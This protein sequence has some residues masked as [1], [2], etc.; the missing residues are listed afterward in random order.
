M[1]MFQHNQSPPLG[2]HQ[3]K[4]GIHST[5]LI[6][7]TGVY[8]LVLHAD[9][10]SLASGDYPFSRVKGSPQDTQLQGGECISSA[11]PPPVTGLNQC[12]KLPPWCF[13]CCS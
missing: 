8:A 12:A 13:K 10:H 6:L 11:S 3:R 1:Y 4:S 9:P 2:G 5:V 7:N